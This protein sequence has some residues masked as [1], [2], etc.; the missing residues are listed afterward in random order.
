M[1]VVR[2]FGKIISEKTGK[3]LIN[4]N[5]LLR[6]ALRDAGKNPNI[7]VIDEIKYFLKNQ[8]KDLLNRVDIGDTDEIIQELISELMKNQSLFTMSV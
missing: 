5:G 4:C 7:L 8:V 1:D 6:L 3:K 2:F